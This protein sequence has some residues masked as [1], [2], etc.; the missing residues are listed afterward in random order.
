MKKFRKTLLILIATL[1]LALGAVFAV[2]CGG[3]T[4]KDKNNGDETHDVTQPTGDALIL[5]TK[6]YG[7]YHDMAETDKTADL[8]VSAA[9]VKWG[10]K[11]V[12]LAEPFEDGDTSYTVK[13]GD[14]TYYLYVHD[15]GQ[16]DLLDAQSNGP[17]FLKDGVKLEFTVTVT[18]NNTSYGTATLDPQKDK[19]TAGE[20]VTLTVAPAEGCSLEFATL[21]GESVSFEENAYSFVV[22]TDTVINVYFLADGEIPNEFRG[23][24][25]NLEDSTDSFTLT[26]TGITWEGHEATVTSIDAYVDY[27]DST[28]S[29]TQLTVTIDGDAGNNILLLYGANAVEVRWMN[30]DTYEDHYYGLGDGKLDTGLLAAGTFS[31]VGGEA[32][33]SLSDDGT[34]SLDGTALKVY[35]TGT[36][37]YFYNEELYMLSVINANYVTVMNVANGD[38]VNYVRDSIS[39]TAHALLVGEWT[40]SNG[41]KLVVSA[42]GTMTLTDVGG[43]TAIK[44]VYSD[45]KGSTVLLTTASGTAVASI[46]LSFPMGPGDSVS[47]WTTAW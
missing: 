29:G 22:S 46:S 4:D 16:I 9:G 19:Y 27:F 40:E 35:Y 42:D 39:A 14:D 37:H 26:A 30:G 10:D 7:T 13:V 12:F 1:C 18:V 38:S 24:W 43:L 5:D 3:D 17:S 25:T 31:E 34:V 36:Y 8:V 44:L 23:T 11:D 6:Y 15:N 21:N 28:P 2:A 47:I 41:G 32:K 33:L 45:L 20:T